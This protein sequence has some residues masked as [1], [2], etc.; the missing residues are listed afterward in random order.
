M[1]KPRKVR[2]A[3][4]PFAFTLTKEIAEEA[5]RIGLTGQ[6]MMPLAMMRTTYPKAPVVVL[7]KLGSATFINGKIEI[8][9]AFNV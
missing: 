9:G 8:G 3:T 2:D 5:R 7:S 6:Q 1:T 4:K